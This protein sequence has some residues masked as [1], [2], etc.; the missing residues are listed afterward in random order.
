M[1]CK[2]Y[3]VLCSM[4]FFKLFGFSAFSAISA[5]KMCSRYVSEADC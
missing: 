5:L 3:D 1:T 4:L 2:N